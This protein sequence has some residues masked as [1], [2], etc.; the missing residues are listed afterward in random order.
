VA[1]GLK[2]K[3]VQ[4]NVKAR[5]DGACKGE[6]HWDD[7]IRSIAPRALDVFIVHVMDRNLANVADLC[8]HMDK[9]YEYLNNDLS[10]KGFEDSVH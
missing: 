10:I 9:P 7:N 3:V 1:K 6:N 8:G 4:V 5:I 2:R